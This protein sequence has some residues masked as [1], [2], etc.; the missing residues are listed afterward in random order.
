MKTI[1]YLTAVAFAALLTGCGSPVP[2]CSDEQSTDLV[3]EIAAR[4]MSNQLGD[5]AAASFTY[6]VNAI[7]TTSTNEGTGAHE[8]AAELAVIGPGGTSPLP[9]TYT[10]EQT[11]DGEQFYINVFGL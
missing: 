8:C 4:E 6:A 3:K 1:K 11:D 2:V 7:R 10:I 9:I 5:A